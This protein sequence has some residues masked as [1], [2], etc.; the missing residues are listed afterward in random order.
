MG[1]LRLIFFFPFVI[2]GLSAW[3]KGFREGNQK[4]LTDGLIS[5]RGQD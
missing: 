2:I 4:F 1:I 3:V 5:E